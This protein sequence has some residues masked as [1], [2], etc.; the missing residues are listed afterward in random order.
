MWL[1]SIAHCNPPQQR[2]HSL[3][4]GDAWSQCLV[5]AQGRA[6]HL[7]HLQA[8]KPKLVVWKISCPKLLDSIKSISR[9]YC[10]KLNCQLAMEE[11]NVA[12]NT[13]TQRSKLE[14]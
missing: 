11:K 14:N 12:P 9:R 6:N 1:W 5:G 7:P 13:S 2:K 3:C 10:I 8:L 4:S